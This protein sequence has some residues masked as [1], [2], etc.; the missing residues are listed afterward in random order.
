MPSTWTFEEEE[1]H[2]VWGC[3]KISHSIMSDMTKIEQ[4]G[5]RPGNNRGGSDSPSTRSYGALDRQ[6]VDEEED[7]GCL[8]TSKS[9]PLK[10]AY[11]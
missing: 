10:S 9:K 1:A 2:V 5:N 6:P 11:A 8:Y 7:D 4:S 3:R